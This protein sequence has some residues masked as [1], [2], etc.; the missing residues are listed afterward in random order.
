MDEFITSLG[1]I[2]RK[3]PAAARG[4]KPRKNLNSEP[5]LRDVGKLV[6]SSIFKYAAVLNFAGNSSAPH[7]NSTAFVSRCL[8]D[9]MDYDAEKVS[10]FSG[11]KN[12]NLFSTDSSHLSMVGIQ[13][14]FSKV[15]EDGIASSSLFLYVTGLGGKSEGRTY[16]RTPHTGP[17]NRSYKLF[18]DELKDMLPQNADYIVAV[19]DGDYADDFA[20][21][22]SGDNVVSIATSKAD[23]LTFRH[24]GVSKKEFD[25]EFS[26]L[27]TPYFFSALS[28]RGVDGEIIASA[29]N[30]SKQTLYG[31][32]F[33]ACT[34]S[35]RIP[36]SVDELSYLLTSTPVIRSGKNVNPRNMS[37]NEYISNV[38]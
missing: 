8:I 23:E 3:F 13:D 37:I 21:A 20:N 11:T 17:L 38:K 33:E 36:S 24:K 1:E 14:A 35:R 19:F 2:F 16:F 34:K 29:E 9:F 28:G 26:S 32:F 18:A 10:V 4:L 5:Y 12:V 30:T 15:N 6:D 25:V 22:V 27:F 7:F 31:C